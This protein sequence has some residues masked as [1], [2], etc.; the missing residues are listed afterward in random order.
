MGHLP[1]MK[2]GLALL[3]L[4]SGC[5]VSLDIPDDANI[6]CNDD[7]DCPSGSVCDA[8]QQCRNLA[9]AA[10]GLPGFDVTP[11]ELTI[12]ESGIPSTVN[13]RLTSQPSAAVT[14]ILAT[15]DGTEA[16][17]SKNILTF[18]PENYGVAQAV[19]VTGERDCL[20]DG[21]VA[22]HIVIAPAQ[23]EDDDYS[24]LDAPDVTV[25]TN[26]DVPSAGITVT[27]TTGLETSE[28]GNVT[29]F[30][31]VV[32][33][34]PTA[35]VHFALASTNTSEGSIA[36]S[37]LTF[38]PDN[39]AVPRV[40]NVAGK[41][42]CAA[43]GDVDYAVTLGIV[44]SADP[45][46][47]GID[48]PDVQLVNRDVAFSRVNISP[49]SGL[50]TSEAGGIATFSVVLTCAPSATVS[51]PIVSG[52]T[53]EGTVNV[54]T[55]TFGPADWNNAQA[56]VITGK[57]DRFDD[58][59]VAY[60]IA[61]GAMTSTDAGFS[62][63]DPID[64]GVTNDDDDTASITVT[65]LTGL[66][67]A[68]PSTGVVFSVQLGAVPT[69]QVT[70]TA[71]S[72][73]PTQA[74]IT[75]GIVGGNITITD[76]ALHQVSVTAVDDFVDENA[77]TFSIVLGNIVSADPA[78]SGMEV[79][80]VTIINDDND[81]AG[82]ASAGPNSENAFVFLMESGPTNNTSTARV[83]LTSKPLADVVLHAYA[84]EPA[85]FQVTAGVDLT[86]TPSNWQN[87]Q[88]VTLAGKNDGV[89]DT[90]HV[91][92]LLF[93]ASSADPKYTFSGNGATYVNVID[94][95]SVKYTYVTSTLYAAN[96]VR[97]VDADAKCMTAPPLG[98]TWKAAIVD[99]STRTVCGN[100]GTC[101]WV[102]AP[103]KTYMWANFRG[104]LGV[105]N[106]SGTFTSPGS[107]FSNGSNYAG[108][109][110]WTGLDDNL[111]TGATCN[112]WTSVSNSVTGDVG[113][114]GQSF[115]MQT[116]SQFAAACD[117]QRALF[118]IQQ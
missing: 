74:T 12:G 68:E 92:A 87:Q 107:D 6:T 80:D 51:V 22:S 28:T 56:V 32:A 104:M 52:D 19:I 57:D 15:D 73:D 85:E 108:D 1:Q 14:V 75:G 95:A 89:A 64:V 10:R 101:G 70:I 21:P 27:P 4:L 58:G 47:A 79:P 40:I 116:F 94:A 90:F 36:V 26:D 53:S 45:L 110:Y 76:D 111:A 38:T 113:Y 7:A 72:S 114:T 66:R 97:P 9:V 34:K 67:T 81:T 93:D 98:G 59:N 16:S 115:P 31:V 25:T 91:S 23:S 13:V 44:D 82:I 88:L 20:A 106:A 60:T 100:P 24:G 33:C 18:T 29:Q 112:Q 48:P 62:G 78:F 71:V 105:P 41:G 103:G 63:V 37:D 65:P 42:D 109:A 50:R 99:G 83:N 2:R 8:R 84:Q 102:F 5:S 30:S 77:V 11:T 118:C 69:S 86:F 117:T 43:D 3:V 55:L 96:T 46:Y 35:D 17:I 54:T 61:T 49:N 39:W